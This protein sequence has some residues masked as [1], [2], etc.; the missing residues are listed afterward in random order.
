MKLEELNAG[1]DKA[2]GKLEA[3]KEEAK[4][5]QDINE[6]L[7][8]FRKKLSDHDILRTFD[9]HVFE[10]IVDRVIVGEKNENGEIAPYK[11]KFIFKTGAEK[12][13]ALEQPLSSDNPFCK[14]VD[15]SDILYS[16]TSVPAC[17]DGCCVRQG[18]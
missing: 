13:V 3:L 14:A 6:R 9:R 12:D 10:C 15:E 1:F 17:R 18:I 7:E 2:N 16:K 11:L 4:T 8:V 5:R